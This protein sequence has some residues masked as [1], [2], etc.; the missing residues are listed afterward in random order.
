LSRWGI[1]LNEIKDLAKKIIGSPI[2]DIYRPPDNLQDADFRHY[3]GVDQIVAV[4][5]TIEALATVSWEA[6]KAIILDFESKPI[7]LEALRLLFS[8]FDETEAKRQPYPK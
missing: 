5:E 8:I 6:V 1:T 7:Q 2:E 4:A 3:I